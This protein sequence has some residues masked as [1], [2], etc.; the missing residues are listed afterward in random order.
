[1]RGPAF[2]GREHE[3]GETEA[4][5]DVHLH[6]CF[7]LEDKEDGRQWKR[8]RE[9]DLATKNEKKKNENRVLVPARGSSQQ[10]AG[11]VLAAACARSDWF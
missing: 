7:A 4:S 3:G 5:D 2:V 9:R 10:A 6:C 11:I 8:E 1:M